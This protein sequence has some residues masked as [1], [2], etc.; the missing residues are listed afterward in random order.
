MR[1]FVF[2]LLLVFV[3]G[4]STLSAA[5][6]AKAAPMQAGL[7][8]ATGTIVLDGV[9]GKQ[10]SWRHRVNLPEAMRFKVY[11]AYVS[12]ADVTYFAMSRLWGHGSN[13]ID[14]YVSSQ[15]GNMLYPSRSVSTKVTYWC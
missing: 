3:L 2:C 15:L 10:H 5:V 12:G 11:K 4:A 14:Y 9:Y 6:P 8:N 1:K 7:C 13:Y